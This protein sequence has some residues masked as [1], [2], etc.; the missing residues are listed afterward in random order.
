M[1]LNHSYEKLT[2]QRNDFLH[3]L[4]TFYVCNYGAIAIEDLR[5]GN[6]VRNHNYAKSILDASWGKFF[7]MLEYKAEGAGVRVVKVNPQG[8]SQEHKEIDDRDYRA[9]LN[10]LERGLSGSGLPLVPVEKEPL[11]VEIP[12]SSVV[13]AGSPHH[14]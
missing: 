12:A 11:L 8:T 10:I 9:S 1:T 4:S 6:M 5:I 14:S 3:K 7:N 13:E 2:N